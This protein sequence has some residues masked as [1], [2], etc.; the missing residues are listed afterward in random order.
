MEF[1]LTFERLLLSNVFLADVHERKRATD[2]KKKEIYPANY[3]MKQFPKDEFLVTML[4]EF[5][6]Q[7]LSLYMDHMEDVNLGF[8]AMDEVPRRHTQRI[9]T[10]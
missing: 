8:K 4:I 6:Y 3:L 2:A 1:D 10:R 5:S 9:V 7:D